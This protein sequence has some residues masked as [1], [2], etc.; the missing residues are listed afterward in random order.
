MICGHSMI[1]IYSD[2]NTDAIAWAIKTARETQTQRRTQAKIYQGAVSPL[3]AK[4][5]AL[6][7]GLF[8]GVGVFA[9]RNGDD[10]QFMVDN[11]AMI[12]SLKSRSSNDLFINNRINHI[13]A[14][15]RQRCLT[16]SVYAIKPSANIATPLL[17][18]C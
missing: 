9:V 4:F 12:S 2:G 18:T 14:L 15:I 6:H 1:S 11:H 17:L 13:D 5:M 8:W 10:V 3:Q 16:V 7:V